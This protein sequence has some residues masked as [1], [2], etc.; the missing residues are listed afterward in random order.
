ML[1]PSSNKQ[2]QQLYL[3]PK[4]QG[5]KQL[6]NKAI[7]T[8]LKFRNNKNLANKLISYVEKAATD[9]KLDSE[10]YH[11]SHNL[12]HEILFKSQE[13]HKNEFSREKNRADQLKPIFFKIIKKPIISYLD[14]GCNE[15]KITESVGQLLKAPIIRGCDVIKTQNEYNFEFTLLNPDNPYVLPYEKKSQDVV[16]AFMSLHHIE[17]IDKTLSEIK[18]ILKHGGIF[19]IREH[20]CNPP[21][22]ELLLDLMHGFYAM[23]WADPSEMKDFSTHF[24]KYRTKKDMIEL[25]EKHGFKIIYSDEPRGAWQYYYAAFISL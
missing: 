11:E 14:L 2:I 23:V 5:V 25:I 8:D 18:R 1:K 24:S 9:K 21:E 15:G 13:Y 16:T 17:E 12:V 10:I 20:D 3:D 7:L 4:F 22:L 6:F 19:L